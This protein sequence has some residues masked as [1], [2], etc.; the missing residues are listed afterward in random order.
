MSY[1]DRFCSAI[2]DAYDQLDA[3]AATPQAKEIALNRKVGNITAA[4]V[5]A[6]DDNPVA[7]LLDMLV[8]ASLTRAS[9]EDAWF[10]A[11]FGADGV[12]V[13]AVHRQ[14]EDEIWQIA[15]QYLSARQLGELHDSIDH[16]RRDHP[17]Q[18]YV[19]M[20]RLSDIARP[21]IDSPHGSRDPGSVFHLLFLDPFASLDPAVREVERSRETAERVFYYMQR[22]PMILSGQAELAARRSLEAPQVGSFLGDTSKFTDSTLRFADATLAVADAIKQFPQFMTEERQRAIEQA[23]QKV[24]EQR[25]AAIKQMATAVAAERDAAVKQ[26]SGVVATE[27]EA[28]ISQATTRAS[29]ESDELLVHFGSLLQSE[30]TDLIHGV[31]AT[32]KGLIDRILWGQVI[33]VLISVVAVVVG[34]LVYRVLRPR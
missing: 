30:R 28:A 29:A 21:R 24:T 33:V 15:A 26:V 12:R 31:D 14:L 16:W 23:N 5:N 1:A 10:T 4:I 7:G 25:D 3:G 22:M 6:S 32:A 11:A 17:E 18:R 20:V 9:T 2:A 13:V 8:M 27:R 19:A 34:A